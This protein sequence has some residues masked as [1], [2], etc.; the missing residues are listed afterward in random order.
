V[1]DCRTTNIW[2]G[3][4]DISSFA[5]AFTLPARL[6]TEAELDAVPDSFD[7]RDDPLAQ[8]TC[9]SITEIRDQA[10]CGSCWAFG[11]SE[12]MTDRLCIQSNGT[13]AA[14]L[15]AQDV[16]SCC[17]LADLGCNGGVPPSVYTYY[18]TEGVVSGGNYGDA[19]G[20][21]AYELAPCAHHVDSPDYAPCDDGFTRT[22]SCARAC[23]DPTRLD[24]SDAKIKGGRGYSVCSKDD[25]GSA[26][27]DGT[28]TCAQKMAAEIVANGPIT[29][30]YFVHEDFLSYAG[31]VYEATKHSRMLGGHAIKI[32]GFGTEDDVPYWLVANSWNEEW[33]M[34]GFFKIKRGSN[35]CQIEDPVING[36]PAAGMAKLAAKRF[37]VGIVEPSPATT[38]LA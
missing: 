28:S 22:P 27:A 36:G 9:P 3:F 8:T 1:S 10:N 11:T 16:T 14:H 32:L 30:Q 29:A 38:M 25:A 17:H 7:W 6:F 13:L 37:A 35:E 4:D 34:D 19:S 20:C 18:E 5:G 26:R 33:G 21:Y 15:S 23:D 12:A 31:G 2:G 24:W